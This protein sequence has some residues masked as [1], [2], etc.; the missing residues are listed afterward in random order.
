[1]IG[2]VT[3]FAPVLLEGEATGVSGI[4]STMQTIITALIDALGDFTQF[5]LSDSLAVM[6]MA[7]TFI[8][9][10]IHLLHSLVHKFA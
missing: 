3:T 7:I 9:L 4:L 10:A 2:L 1:M 8:M 5:I 6:F